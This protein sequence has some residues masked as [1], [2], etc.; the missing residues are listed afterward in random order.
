MATTIT[1]NTATAMATA[2]N[3]ANPGR[4]QAAAGLGN[5]APGQRRP[6][7]CECSLRGR[8]RGMIFLLAIL[9]PG[10]WLLLLAARVGLA[11]TWGESLRL[12]TLRRAVALDRFNPELHFKLGT[13]Y[14]W[15]EGGNPW[16][17]AEELREATRLNRNAAE[18]WSALGK[19]CYAS[20]Q[21]RCSDQAFERATRLNP[22]K[23]RF[24]WEAALHYAIT[25]RPQA[26]WPHLRRLLRWQPERAPQAFDMLLRTGDDPEPV[27][28]Q[29]ASAAGPEVSLSYLSFLVTHSRLAAAEKFW[30]ELSSARSGLPLASA[31]NYVEELL[32]RGHYRAAAQVWAYLQGAGVVG[33]SPAPSLVFNGGFERPPL[34][35]GFDWHVQPQTYL[36]VDFADPG[37]HSGARALRLEFTVPDNADYEPVYQF[38]PV[39]PGR[40]YLLSAQV[41]SEN[42]T[43]D[44]GPRLRVADPQCAACLSLAS[45]GT[46]GTQSWQVVELPF[47]APAAAEVI[48]LSVWRPRSRSFPMSISGRFWLDDVDLRPLAA[49]PAPTA[50][51]GGRQ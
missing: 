2:A 10:V 16:A 5:R 11:A 26:A 46:V 49:M 9:L 32:R 13:A 50:A 34:P 1:G 18:Y 23:P 3:S 45:A 27:W 47:A 12:P 48:R 8:S 37:A 44:S 42:I 40:Q 38:I 43:S 21:Q 25:R 17:A 7:I 19:A 24:A 33:G 41:R 4:P 28:R 31:S 39:T 14:L 51:A 20:G 15:A 30:G 35:A 29:L 6:G 36:T 22:S